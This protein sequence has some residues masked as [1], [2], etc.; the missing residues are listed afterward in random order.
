M[1]RP[2]PI[3][4][5]A[6]D[7]GSRRAGADPLL[8][9]VFDRCG[10]SA[11]SITY[12]GAASGDDQRFFA[13]V[14]S[15]FTNSGAGVV[16]LAPTVRQFE[17]RSFEKTCAVSDAVFFSGGDVD[18][19]INV[20]TEHRLAP[21]FRELYGGGKLFFGISAGS[22]MLARTW[23]RFRGDG[24]SV[25]ELFPCLGIADILVDVHDEDGNWGELS[26]LLKLSPDS[27][28]GYGIRAGSAIVVDPHGT[29]EPMGMIDTL[30]KQGGA[31]SCQ[32]AGKP[33]RR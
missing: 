33:R 20:V 1:N 4:L 31:L 7:P 13:M 19:G 8:R 23:V 6:G 5:I 12:I 30:V 25:G 16:T 28:V 2:K 18:E 14:T 29:V 9:T 32:S 15:A 17:R 10:A 24:D 21:F 11:P 3:F 26:A 22:I 27:S